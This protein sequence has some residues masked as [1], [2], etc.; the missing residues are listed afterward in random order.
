MTISLSQARKCVTNPVDRAN[1][2]NWFSVP[3]GDAWLWRIGS[4]QVVVKGILPYAQTRPL[5]SSIF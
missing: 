3:V 1:L 2:D 5:L 4:D